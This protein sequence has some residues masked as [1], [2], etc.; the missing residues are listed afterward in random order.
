MKSGGSM[1]SIPFFLAQMEMVAPLISTI[2]GVNNKSMTTTR[3]L[4]FEPNPVS[5]SSSKT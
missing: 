1:G 3:T 4:A 5:T 2:R